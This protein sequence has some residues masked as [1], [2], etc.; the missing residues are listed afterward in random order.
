MNKLSKLPNRIY[1]SYDKWEE[2][3]YNCYG[4]DKTTP[5]KINAV[6]LFFKNQK[7]VREFMYKAV[8]EFRFSCEHNLKNPSMNKIAF[9]GQ[10]AVARYCR[11][12]EHITRIAWNY[13]DEYTQTEANKIAIDAIELFYVFKGWDHTKK[14]L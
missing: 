1:H 13:L 14:I 8:N 7:L 11:I 12:P 5:E 6:I 2:V 3:A 4:D 10:I 9:I